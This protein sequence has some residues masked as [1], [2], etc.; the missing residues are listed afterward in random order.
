MASPQ[1]AF[2]KY[3]SKPWLKSYDEGVPSEIEIP[4]KPLYWI[5]EQAAEQFPNRTALH[6][7]GRNV[8]YKE[9]LDSAKRFASYLKSRGI[10]KGDVVGLFLP[11]SPM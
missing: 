4:E 3:S 10:G 6:F 7:L 11:N 9:L 8:S 5:L 2:E 1:E